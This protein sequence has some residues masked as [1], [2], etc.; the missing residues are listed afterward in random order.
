[1]RA[2]SLVWS[3]V[4]ALTVVAG[5]ALALSIETVPAL[6]GLFATVT[7][8]VAV[9]A[10][11]LRTIESGTSR[12]LATYSRMLADSV[13][14]GL[15][16]VAAFGL[17]LTIGAWLVL[18]VAVLA[19]TSPWTYD[20]VSHRASRKGRSDIVGQPRSLDVRDGNLE[21][22][23]DAELYAVWQATSAR[24]AE[25]A[26]SQATTAAQ[27]RELLL[28]EI[29]RRYPREAGRWLSSDAALSGE[30]P[31]FLRPAGEG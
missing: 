21:T 10:A 2:Y 31:H 11:N 25:A 4:T 9:I 14:V 18:A 7:I 28:T 26:D 27:A 16:G 20:R 1:M 15:A 23:T 6:L 3:T 19:V 22:W 24:V 17:G 5:I 12:W 13:V 8:C 29:E 30:A